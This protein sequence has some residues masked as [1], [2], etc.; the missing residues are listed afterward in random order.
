MRSPNLYQPGTVT[1]DDFLLINCPDC[2]DY[3]EIEFISEKLDQ[4]LQGRTGFCEF[5]GAL[6]STDDTSDTMECL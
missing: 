1:P 5:L 3:K 2:G 4:D 6:V